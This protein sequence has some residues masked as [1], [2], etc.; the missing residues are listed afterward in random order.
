[1][2]SMKRQTG[3]VQNDGLPQLGG[4]RE[5]LQK[6]GE[7]APERT[8]RRNKNENN[9]QLWMCLMMEVKSDAIKNNIA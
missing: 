8:K 2:N 3:A 6:S 1:M 7:S 9:T 5:P 4:A